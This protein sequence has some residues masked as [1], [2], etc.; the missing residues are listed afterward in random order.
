M[1]DT[2]GASA[3]KSDTNM[4]NSVS[5]HAEICLYFIFYNEVSCGN[6]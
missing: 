4:V 3:H 1:D 6:M 5:D 2:G